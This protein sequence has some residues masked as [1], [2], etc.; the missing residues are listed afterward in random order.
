MPLNFIHDFS[1]IRE[2]LSKKTDVSR[3]RHI[4]VFAG[5]EIWQKNVL[6]EIL[7]GYE[8]S[9]LWVADDPPESYPN[10]LVK[11]VKS[12]LGREKQIVIF[13]ANKDFSADGFAAI[14][15]IVVG[16]GLFI[17][18]MPAD[19][20]WTKIYNTCFGQRI[21]KS[22]QSSKT[23][24]IIKQNDSQI[25][26]ATAPSQELE[27]KSYEVPFLSSD[28]EDVVKTLEKET[29]NSSKLPVVLTSDRGR[30]KS[31]ALGIMAARLMKSGIKKIIITAPR[32]LAIDIVFKHIQQLL[33][34]AEKNRGKI[35]FENSVI[36]FYA[37]DQLSID[38]LHQE[39]LTADLLLVDEAAA[40]PVPLLISFLK[41]FPQCIFST[42]VHGYEGTGRGFSV[43]FN[44]ILDQSYPG[45]VKLKMTIPIRWAE[46]DPLEQ[47]MFNLLC[48]N[49]EITDKK[50]I[51][52][53]DNKITISVVDQKELSKNDVLLDEIFSLLVTAHYRTQ[54][55]DLQRLLD[56]REISIY[57]VNNNQHVIAVALVNHEGNF[58]LELS[59]EVYRGERRPSGHLLA[60]ALTY[61]CGVEHAANLNY[62]RVMRIAVHPEY[63]EQGVGSKLLDYIVSNEN[64]QGYDA[65][66]TSFGLNS[67]L[68]SFW[69][70]SGFNVIRVGFKREQTS[71]EHAAIMMQALNQRGEEVYDIAYER[72]YEQLPYWFD[73]VLQYIP[74]EIKENF[75]L[76]KKEN[77][78]QL[79]NFDNKDIYSFINYS[80]NYEL[81]IAAL[82]KLV[83]QEKKIVSDKIFP[84][85][86]SRVLIAKVIEEK[87]WKE[88]AVE[89]NLNGKA[90]SRAL[91]KKAIVQL[92]KLL[93]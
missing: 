5:D 31:A 50:L 71:G 66:G 25:K 34:E 60:Q 14:S 44:K 24:N 53:I 39:S 8:E 20:N 18:L 11:K 37:P 33:P 52:E 91:F 62:S 43:R 28:Q 56:D 27:K 26:L 89:M 58:P 47:W 3:H 80:R 69:R 85:D 16:G 6:K 59:T 65:I 78:V 74:T 64:Q 73:D 87:G 57:V 68:L 1:A 86:F 84:D 63:Q 90:G 35:T 88:I 46:N 38:D 55:S 23:I 40:V 72:F 67:R 22:I 70:A 77:N 81:C 12:W 82:N 21:I 13:D 36:Q 54:P 17:L 9:S 48:L 92:L 75:V 61:H 4:F 49:A 42:T 51:G 7:H 93:E 19:K 76:N 29:Y 2:I 10:I 15:G 83:L 45:W 32:M 30:G 41:N 79:S